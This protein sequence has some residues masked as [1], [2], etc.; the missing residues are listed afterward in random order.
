[1]GVKVKVGDDLG[2]VRVNQTHLYQI[3]ANLVRNAIHHSGADYLEIEIVLLPTI[4]CA[5]HRYLVK[6][7][8]V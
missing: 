6:D 3:F 4:E 1:M 5:T 2:T 7:N 8:G